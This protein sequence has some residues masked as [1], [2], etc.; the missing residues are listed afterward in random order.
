MVIHVIFDRTAFHIDTN[1][2]RSAIIVV[3][4][5]GD[6]C[7]GHHSKKNSWRQD[8]NLWEKLF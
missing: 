4:G 3:E 5:N 7:I 1:E 2:M 8:P 6:D